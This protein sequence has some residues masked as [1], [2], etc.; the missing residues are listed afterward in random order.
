MA[1]LTTLQIIRAGLTPAFAAAAAGGDTITDNDGLVFLYV[2][3]GGAGACSVTVTAS[4]QCNQ[5]GTHNTVVSVPAAS[6][7][8]LGPFPREQ[9]GSVPAVTYSTVTSVTVAVYRLGAA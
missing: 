3:N 7:R 1:L 4:Q 2:K 6:E 5:G 8:M 9:F